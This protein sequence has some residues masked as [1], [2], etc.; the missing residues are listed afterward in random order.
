MKSLT[1]EGNWKTLG[2][3]M[4]PGGRQAARLWLPEQLWALSTPSVF[5][6][7]A[8]SDSW[9]PSPA[10][11]LPTLENSHTVAN[12]SHLF[13][14]KLQGASEQGLKKIPEPI[15]EATTLFYGEKRLTK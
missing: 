2:H 11:R 5:Q 9:A 8:Q 12:K 10:F 14:F 1:G 3:S 4:W 6:Q 13:L 15:K 7:S